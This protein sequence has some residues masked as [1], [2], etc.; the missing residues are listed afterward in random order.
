MK[1]SIL[2]DARLR[3][4]ANLVGND[5]SRAVGILELTWHFAATP[6]RSGFIPAVDA[7]ELAGL[8]TWTGDSAAILAVLVQSKWACP[9]DNGIILAD[10]EENRP[11]HAVERDKKRRQRHLSRGQPPSKP[12]VVPE[13]GT[14]KLD[15]VPGTGTTQGEEGGRGGVGVLNG[16]AG[17]SNHD[18][19]PEK[20][21]PS[22]SPQADEPLDPGLEFLQEAWNATKGT[23]ECKALN[24]ARRRAY[25]ARKKE[26]AFMDNWLEALT[27]F[28]LHCFHVRPDGWQ[29]DIDWFLRPKTVMAILE[30]KYD[31]DPREERDRPRS[32]DPNLFKDGFAD[33]T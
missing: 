10:W 3:T 31:Y 30:G 20:A 29:P 9:G 12:P 15:V 28:P 22:P 32:L 7:P 16:R 25:N 4:L 19:T 33:D 21:K 1:S 13:T 18:Y 14:L 2:S 8:L 17:T 24:S 23:R 26:R 27:K 6:E 11:A 5:F